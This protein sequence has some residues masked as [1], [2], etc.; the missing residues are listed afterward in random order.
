MSSRYLIQPHGNYKLPPFLGKPQWYVAYCML[1]EMAEYKNNPHR[2]ALGR[3]W[4][5]ARGQLATS[6]T[7]LHRRLAVIKVEMT[8]Q[9]IRTLLKHLQN[10]QLINITTNKGG[11]VVTI[12]NYDEWHQRLSQRHTPLASTTDKPTHKVYDKQPR[13][14]Q[15]Y[16]GGKQLTDKEQQVMALFRQKQQEVRGR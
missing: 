13:Y 2:Y 6:L 15:K 14:Y 12:C 5:L 8:I 10:A 11:M 16:Q 1:A 3:V 4:V 9:N 7:D